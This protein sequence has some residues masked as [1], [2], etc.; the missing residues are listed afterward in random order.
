MNGLLNYLNLNLSLWWC[1]LGNDIFIKTILD[2]A[3]ELEKLTADGMNE[4]EEARQPLFLDIRDS[5][6]PLPLPGSAEAGNHGCSWG[7]R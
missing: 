3:K 7:S 5:S 2:Y 1:F 4:R 6:P